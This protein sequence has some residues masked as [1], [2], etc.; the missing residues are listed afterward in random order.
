MHYRYVNSFNIYCHDFSGT[1]EII[2]MIIL[3]ALAKATEN[4]VRVSEVNAAIS[5]FRDHGR[6]LHSWLYCAVEAAWGACARCDPPLVMRFVNDPIDVLPTSEEAARIR[7]Q[8]LWN[9]VMDELRFPDRVEV[10]EFDECPNI[11]PNRPDL[12]LRPRLSCPKG[13]IVPI[14][15]PRRTQDCFQRLVDYQLIQTSL[16]STQYAA[17]SQR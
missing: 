12:C 9:T 13:G 2:F 11:V 3:C 15:L 10:G 14:Q 1:D 16:P 8:R 7:R 6:P 4:P 17:W 5:H